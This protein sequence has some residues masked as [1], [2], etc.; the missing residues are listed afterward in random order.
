M[1]GVL[2]PL[3][4]TSIPWDP[5]TLDRLSNL[6]WRTEN[7]VLRTSYF[8]AFSSDD[9]NSSL[10]LDELFTFFT[11][12]TLVSLI[13]LL[14]FSSSSSEISYTGGPLSF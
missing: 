2:G 13:S 3:T 10:T 12:S 8:S 9:R 14:S 4:P 11:S 5:S 6:F 1:V 7:S